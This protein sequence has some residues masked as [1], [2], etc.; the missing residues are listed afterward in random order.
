MIKIGQEKIC[1]V[2][3]EVVPDRNT[4]S[5]VNDFIE[6]PKKIFVLEF[7]PEQILQYL[8]IDVRVEFLNIKL[9]AILGARHVPQSLS[10]RTCSPMYASS[11]NAAVSI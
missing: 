10:H 8:V 2:L 4:I 7:P 3:A 9:Q 11:F 6:E 5:T 1:K